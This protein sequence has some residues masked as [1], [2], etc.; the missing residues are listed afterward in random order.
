MG[1]INV[2]TVMMPHFYHESPKQNSSVVVFEHHFWRMNIKEN[3]Q[4]SGI[5]LSFHDRKKM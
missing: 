5:M 4:L 1:N 3:I 2:Q